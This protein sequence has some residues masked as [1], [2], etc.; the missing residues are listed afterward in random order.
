MYSRRPKTHA[1]VPERPTQDKY[2]LFEQWLRENGAQFDMVRIC[3]WIF[4]L[5]SLRLS[6]SLFHGFHVCFVLFVLLVYLSHNHVCRFSFF[7]LY[8]W[9]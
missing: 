5:S 8:S 6:L 7:I 9:N 1:V 4:V 3:T 2:D